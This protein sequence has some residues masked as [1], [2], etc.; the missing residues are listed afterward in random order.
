[1]AGQYP[2][3]YDSSSRRLADENRIESNQFIFIRHGII[4]GETLAM[5]RTRQETR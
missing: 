5:V 3:Y 1:M 2:A 4:D